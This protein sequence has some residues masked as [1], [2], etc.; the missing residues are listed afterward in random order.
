M[1]LALHDSSNRVRRIRIRCQYLYK[2]FCIAV[3]NL[4][5]FWY[6]VEFYS[7]KFALIVHCV[8]LLQ[9]LQYL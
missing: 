4:Y 9:I 1:P 6:W 5:C 3:V 8:E 7:K 2:S